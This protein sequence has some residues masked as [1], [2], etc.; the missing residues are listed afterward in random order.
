MH[1]A[2]DAVG[3]RTSVL[4]AQ[5]YLVGWYERLGYVVSGPEYLEDGI[6]H[7]PMRRP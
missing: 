3:D 7:V 2:L 6:A 4:D 5:S 1:V